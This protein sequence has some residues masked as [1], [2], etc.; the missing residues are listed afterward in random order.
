M[1][2]VSVLEEGTRDFASSSLAS[3]N[4]APESG[5]VLGKW[6]RGVTED[7]HTHV[8]TLHPG[9]SFAYVPFNHF[10]PSVDCHSHP[11]HNEALANAKQRQRGVDVNRTVTI[12]VMDTVRSSKRRHALCDGDQPLP[13]SCD[14]HWAHPLRVN[15]TKKKRKTFGICNIYLQNDWAVYLRNQQLVNCSGV[16]NLAKPMPTDR[17]FED[18]SALIPFVSAHQTFFFLSI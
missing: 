1:M 10:I 17:R 3:H 2:M 7:P 5:P 6:P 9:H 14:P 8:A 15:S 13:Y 11:F 12:P 16:T 18:N 4:A